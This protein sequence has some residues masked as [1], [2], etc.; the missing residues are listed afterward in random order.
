MSRNIYFVFL[1]AFFVV[2]YYFGVV[3]MQTIFSIYT[4]GV[5]SVIFICFSYLSMIDRKAL[6]EMILAEVKSIGTLTT[7]GLFVCFWGFVLFVV[8]TL[9]QIATAYAV[10]I[11]LIA[12]L[13]IT[14]V[15]KKIIK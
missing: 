8:Y 12:H 6:N 4:I 2:A 5:A 11:L 9:G 3:W 1:V 15:R 7:S 10:V 14:A 13:Y